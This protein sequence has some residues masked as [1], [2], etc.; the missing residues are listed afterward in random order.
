MTKPQEET[1]GDDFPEPYMQGTLNYDQ[2]PRQVFI[3]VGDNGEAYDDHAVWNLRAYA[4]ERTA[5]E[6]ADRLNALE[7]DYRKALGVAG[8]PERS[9]PINSAGQKTWREA[10]RDK[11]GDPQFEIGCHYRVDPPLVLRP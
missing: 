10:Y 7:R 3:V 4:S 11:A 9:E 6:E 5:Q 1:I 8:W 2:A